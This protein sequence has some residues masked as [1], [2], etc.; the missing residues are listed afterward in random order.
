MKSEIQNIS[1]ENLLSELRCA[2][3][4]KSIKTWL[5]KKCKISQ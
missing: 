4:Y 1:D 5:L 2:A 3:K